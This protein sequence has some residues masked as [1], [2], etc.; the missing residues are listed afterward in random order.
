MGAYIVLATILAMRGVAIGFDTLIGKVALGLAITPALV[1]LIFHL[2]ASIK[3]MAV[4]A[5]VNAQIAET[6][7]A[8]ERA[9]DEANEKF[10]SLIEATQAQITEEE[11]HLQRVEEAAKIF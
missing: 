11:G 7:A 8:F 1:A 4:E 6:S 9:R 10:R 5:Q 3:R 2:S